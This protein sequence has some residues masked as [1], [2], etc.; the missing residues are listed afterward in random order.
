MKKHSIKEKREFFVIARKTNVFR[1]NLGKL[2]QKSRDNRANQ[3]FARYDNLISQHFSLI[4]H[5]KRKARV[6]NPD[7]PRLLKYK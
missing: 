7:F 1:S 2:T 4:V 3:R 5:K 6:R